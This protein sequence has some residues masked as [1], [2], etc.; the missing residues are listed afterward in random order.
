MGSRE[1]VYALS[2][3]EM[4]ETKWEVP[5]TIRTGLAGVG[6]VGSAARDIWQWL[7]IA[8]ALLLVLEWILFGRALPQHS[9]PAAVRFMERDTPRRKAS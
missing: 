6:G 2:L 3:P 8:G 7:A 9:G 4:G 1:L 5:K